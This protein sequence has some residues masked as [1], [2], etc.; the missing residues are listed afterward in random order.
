MTDIRHAK[1][2]PAHVQSHAGRSSAADLETGYAYQVREWRAQRVGLTAL[3]A[4]V[5]AAGL[6][7]VGS[8]STL[9]R[10][11]AI[12]GFL[13]LVFRIAGKRTVAELTSFDL[14]VLLLIGDATQQGLIGEDYSVVTALVA[15]SCLILIDSGLGLI[16]RRWPKID[17]V[18]DGVPLIIVFKGRVLKDR[19]DREGV[20]L[21]DVLEAAR[22]HGIASLDQIEFAV[23]ERHGGIS[24]ITSGSG[25]HRSS[26]NRP[27]LRV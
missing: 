24:I 11:A 7:W 3:V 23:L 19:M 4:F 17:R 10:V 8:P 26:D 14:I 12:Y 16:K 9:L 27:P 25:R 13:L 1:A 6:G 18:V 15:I 2:Q 5:A 21:D 22:E 20:D